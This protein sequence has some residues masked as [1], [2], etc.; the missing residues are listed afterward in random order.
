MCDVKNAAG[1][2]AKGLC[3]R[4]DIPPPLIPMS[5][6][7]LMRISSELQYLKRQTHAYTLRMSITECYT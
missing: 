1:A 2:L 5:L 3:S 4:T 7:V 6:F